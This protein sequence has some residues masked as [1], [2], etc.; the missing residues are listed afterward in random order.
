MERDDPNLCAPV[1]LEL[2]SSPLDSL[3]IMFSIAI[4]RTTHGKGTGLDSRVFVRSV[5]L[6]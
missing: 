6:E 5:S 3:A 1:T 4:M 2:V